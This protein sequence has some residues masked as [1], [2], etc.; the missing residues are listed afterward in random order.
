MEAADAD[1][2]KTEVSLTD[3]EPVLYVFKTMS[4]AQLASCR[5]SAFIPAR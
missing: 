4:E 2:N 5:F 1:G 3:S